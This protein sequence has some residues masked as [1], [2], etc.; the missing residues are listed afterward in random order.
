[1]LY[2]SYSKG[3]KGGGFNG[4]SN[5]ATPDNYE[6]E[7]EESSST[8]IGA[9]LTFLDGNAT[10]N[11]AVFFDEYKNMQRSAFDGESF[12]FTTR[13]AAVA[14]SKG[15]E[16]DGTVRVNDYVTL[17]GSWAYL[18]SEYDDFPDSSCIALPSQPP[19]QQRARTSL[20]RRCPTPQT[21]V[22]M[23]H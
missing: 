19:A 8:E 18:N 7:D 12:A 14:E 23:S 9:K 3:S 10:L 15:V 20:E 21:G 2:A 16:V 22:A 11:V 6:Y 17:V 4:A 5:T 13:N 1:M